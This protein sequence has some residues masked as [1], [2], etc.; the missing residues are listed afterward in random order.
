MHT[1]HKTKQNTPVQNA[2]KPISFPLS[3]ALLETPSWLSRRLWELSPLSE[4]ECF[5]F[6]TSVKQR[7]ESAKTQH[8]MVES[9]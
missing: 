2:L 8:E 7:A 6:L 1:F 5:G 3:L 9:E 4:F